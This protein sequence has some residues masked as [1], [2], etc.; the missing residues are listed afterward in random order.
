MLKAQA[1]HVRTSLSVEQLQAVDNAPELAWRLARR[2][3]YDAVSA[4]VQATGRSLVEPRAVRPPL[5]LLEQLQGHSYQLMGQLSAVKSMLL[6]RRERRE[7]SA[8][9][10]EAAGPVV[11][12][13]DTPDD[14]AAWLDPTRRRSTP[15]RPVRRARR[16]SDEEIE[17]AE[18]ERL[19]H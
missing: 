1:A 6:L 13:E 19:G 11:V 8:R 2:E 10:A 4:L 17:D 12:P 9:A 16:P 18:A 14:V 7:A 5:A 15:E 3:A